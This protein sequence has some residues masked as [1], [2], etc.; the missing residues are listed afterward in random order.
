MVPGSNPNERSARLRHPTSLWS[1]QWPSGQTRND[2]NDP[3]S[4]PLKQ[5]PKLALEVA[6]N[7][8]QEI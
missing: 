2:K 8:W 5:G 1:F 3:E 7:S 6:N 4:V